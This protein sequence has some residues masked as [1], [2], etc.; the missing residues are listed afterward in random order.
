MGSN[1]RQRHLPELCLEEV[2]RKRR[3]PR[4]V[5]GAA[6]LSILVSTLLTEEYEVKTHPNNFSFGCPDAQ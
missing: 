3:K 5:S 4:A 2:T 1:M 6:L